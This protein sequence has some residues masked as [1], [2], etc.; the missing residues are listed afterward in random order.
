MP[1]RRVAVMAHF[2]AGQQ[3]APHVRRFIEQVLG[4]C[5]ELTVVS[6]SGVGDDAQRW[7][8]I[9]PTLT[10][11][12][13]ENVGYDFLSYRYGLD[14]SRIDGDTEVLICNDSFVGTTI[15]MAD[16]WRPMD[17]SPARFWGMTASHERVRVPDGSERAGRRHIQSYFVVFKA[18]VAVS[19]PFR[20]FWEGVVPHDEKWSVIDANEVG[21]SRALIDG[22]LAATSFFRQS[23]GDD[24]LALQRRVWWER[25]EAFERRPRTAGLGWIARQL[26]LAAARLNY[27]PTLLLADRVFDGRLPLVKLQA[28]R[29]DPGNLGASHLLRGCE[30]AWPELFRGVREYLDRTGHA[31]AEDSHEERPT[32]AGRLAGWERLRYRTPGDARD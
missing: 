6:T 18:G 12:E 27:N 29:E 7:A 25:P 14:A 9:H 23:W 32:Q 28:L 8:R 26:P 19:D 4:W 1:K 11:L 21:L 22:G 2:D 31:Y 13:R 24:W 15:P 16:I 10:I 3:L 17:R 30:R 20:T 5:D